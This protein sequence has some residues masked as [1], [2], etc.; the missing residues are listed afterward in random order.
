MLK[1]F[2]V[3]FV[4]VANI[5]SAE[6]P[7]RDILQE[8]R[9]NK[10]WKPDIPFKNEKEPFK[11]ENKETSVI[12]TSGINHLIYT[13]IYHFETDM[14]TEFFVIHKGESTV[15][16][17]NSGSSIPSS[18]KND[19]SVHV[20]HFILVN[21]R[22][23]CKLNDEDW[24]I[25][26]RV[27]GSKGYSLVATLEKSGEILDAK[28]RSLKYVP[29]VYLRELNLEDVFDNADPNIEKVLKDWADR[30]KK[31]SD[32]NDWPEVCR[33]YDESNKLSGKSKSRQI[34]IDYYKVALGQFDKDCKDLL[35]DLVKDDFSEVYK[36]IK[37]LINKWGKTSL[38]LK[39][40]NIENC[41]RN[42]EKI[43]NYVKSGSK[44]AADDLLIKVLKDLP[45][46]L[47]G[48]AN[49]YKKNSK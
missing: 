18:S 8:L 36:K 20:Y 25:R 39:L 35:S 30:A 5:L 1:Y 49:K 32:D 40:D 23:C 29:E 38:K 43:N 27:V 41:I 22:C 45:S 46:F 2:L 21:N 13:G 11:Y 24:R 9:N 33:I 6:E 34:I 3:I 7:W 28:A 37:I 4:L 10:N 14:F 17:S 47:E 19:G 44:K 42:F 16:I 26:E 15:G 12:C 48:Y 31:A